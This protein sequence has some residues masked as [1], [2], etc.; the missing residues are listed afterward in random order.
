M[1]DAGEL[2]LV[3][4]EHMREAAPGAAGASVDVAFGLRVG[5][6]VRCGACGKET[7]SAHYTQVCPSV[8]LVRLPGPLGRMRNLR[9]A[10][11]GGLWEEAAARGDSSLQRAALPP[12][13]APL[14]LHSVM[15]P[16]STHPCC[17]TLFTRSL[18]SLHAPSP[19]HGTTINTPTRCLSSL[20]ACLP[21]CRSTSSTPLLPR[22]AA[23]CA[24]AATPALAPACAA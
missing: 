6:G 20:P 7:Q 16:L 17:A 18:S 11:Q 1:S 4:Y 23:A 19:Y 10:P 2:L 8:S 21:A 5:E 22:C 24:Q 15:P 9:A 12:A 3:L 13:I 14:L